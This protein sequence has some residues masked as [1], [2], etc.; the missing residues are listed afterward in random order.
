MVLWSRGPGPL[1]P[2]G[3]NFNVSAMT[4]ALK[5]DNTETRVNAC[6]ELA[7]AGERAAPAVTALIPLLKDPDPVTRRLAA[8]ALGQVGP[9]ATQAVPALKELLNDS[10]RDVLT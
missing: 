4:A 9:K 8:Y 10:D 5:S 6:I 2:Q 7:K 1:V 3:K